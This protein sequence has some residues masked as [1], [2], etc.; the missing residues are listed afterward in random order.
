MATQTIFFCLFISVSSSGTPVFV[1]KG[2]DVR[3]DVQGYMTVKE[4]LKRLN[5]FQWRF[6]T[7]DNV[8]TYTH[9]IETQ[10]T[11]KYQGR[12]EFFEGN[13]SLLLKNLKEGDS[14]CYTAAVMTVIRIIRLIQSVKL[15]MSVYLFLERV[16]PPVLTVD[17]VSYIN[18]TCNMTVTCRGQKTSVVTSSCNNS[19]CSHV[20][21][22][23]RGAETS[24]VPLLSVYVAGGS[25][26]CNHSNQV[27]WASDTKEIETICLSKSGKTGMCAHTH[28]RLDLVLHAMLTS[29][30]ILL[31]YQDQTGGEEQTS[32]GRTTPTIYSM[33]G[34]PQPQPVNHQPLPEDLPMTSMPESLYAM[35]GKTTSK[36]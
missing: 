2:Q 14:G 25:I 17:S 18:A 15:T 36:Q 16:E 13:F 6:N 3:L 26:I 9:E 7:S 11:P 4:N 19:T 31:Y 1:A 34:L 30:L 24:P 20:G 22:E 29:I 21:G 12:A 35:V 8:V 10:V 33:V 32:P 23:S 27:S 5:R 28:T